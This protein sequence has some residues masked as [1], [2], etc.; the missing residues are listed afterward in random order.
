MKILVQHDGQGVIHSVGV[1]VPGD[2]VQTTL[3]PR[4]GL[5]VSEVE[6]AEVAHPRDIEHLQ[7]LK[8]RYRVDDTQGTA[9][10]VSR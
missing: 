10:L 5:R 2:A 3:R 9:R 8:D 6:A 4:T 1:A 7:G